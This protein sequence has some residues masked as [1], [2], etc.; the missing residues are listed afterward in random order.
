VWPDNV[1]VRWGQD[2][3]LLAGEVVAFGRR[4]PEQGHRLANVVYESRNG[5]S[6]EWYLYRFTDSPE[7]ADE[8]PHG[9]TPVD[10]KSKR[11]W[12]LSDVYDGWTLDVVELTPE[13]IA[14]LFAD[15]LALPERRTPRG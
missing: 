13:I 3:L 14:S 2:S 1:D 11:Q 8:L 15:A 5:S 10:F 4:A 6:Y 7:R 12:M 9:F